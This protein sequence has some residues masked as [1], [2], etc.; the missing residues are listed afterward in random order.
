MRRFS[1]ALRIWTRDPVHEIA[2]DLQGHAREQ[3]ENSL[4]E[5]HGKQ[6]AERVLDAHA[7]PLSSRAGI[8]G[9][10]RVPNASLLHTRRSHPFFSG[11]A[12]PKKKILNL[13]R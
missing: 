10:S 9:R 7:A 2:N 3:V 5:Q 13:P 1:C 6:G 11:N 4:H 12:P 8:V